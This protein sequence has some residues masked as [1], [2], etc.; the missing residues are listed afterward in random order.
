MRSF[1]ILSGPS[2]QIT[3][4]TWLGGLLSLAAFCLLFLLLRTEHANWSDKRLTKTIYV[5]NV[6]KVDTVLVTLS[7][8][9]PNCPCSL[10]S[11]DVHD[12]LQHHREN[13]PMDKY[14]V[15]KDDGNNAKV[16]SPVQRGRS[17]DPVPSGRRQGR[18]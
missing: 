10:I 1:D 2:R 11:L 12:N 14:R 6:S 13:I 18:P 5:D 15:L 7:M 16:S 9:F 17:H 4:S 8:Y 3:K